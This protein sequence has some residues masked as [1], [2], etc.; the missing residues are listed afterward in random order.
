MPG[1]GVNT[2]F[3]AEPPADASY[4]AWKFR[5]ET[6]I[7]SDDMIAADEEDIRDLYNSWKS[8]SI[9]WDEVVDYALDLAY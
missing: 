6:D 2:D 5:I 9:D 4:E 3:G 7:L 8:G 1:P